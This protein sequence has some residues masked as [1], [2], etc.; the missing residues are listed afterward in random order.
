[1]VAATSSSARRTAGRLEQ[2]HPDDLPGRVDEV[3]ARSN[4]FRLAPGRDRFEVPGEL[5]AAW[6]TLRRHPTGSRALSSR[7]IAT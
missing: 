6:E 4:E 7:V 5:T 2:A 1:M 3:A